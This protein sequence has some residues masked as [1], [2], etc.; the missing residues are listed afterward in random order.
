[1]CIGFGCVSFLPDG[2]VHVNEEIVKRYSEKDEKN[3]KIRE[4]LYKEK[5]NENLPNIDQTDLDKLKKL[6]ISMWPF[7]I[8]FFRMNDNVERTVRAKFEQHREGLD[9]G[10]LFKTDYE[11]LIKAGQITQNLKKDFVGGGELNLMAPGYPRYSKGELYV[12]D[13][14]FGIDFAKNPAK[15]INKLYVGYWQDQRPMQLPLPI[16]GGGG[17]SGSPLIVFWEKGVKVIGVHSSGNHN[18]D[19]STF[20][21]IQSDFSKEFVEAIL[22]SNDDDISVIQQAVIKHN[23]DK[24]FSGGDLVLNW[25]IVVYGHGD[26]DWQKNQFDGKYGKYKEK[27]K[28]LGKDEGWASSANLANFGDNMEDSYDG[29]N[30][31]YV[32]NRYIPGFEKVVFTDLVLMISVIICLCASVCALIVGFIVAIVGYAS[33]NKHH[34]VKNQDNLR[35]LDENEEE[36]HLV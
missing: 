18:Y 29:D 30:N 6:R 27:P 36:Q 28:K 9:V 32:Q 25:E 15:C 20:T 21:I 16:R 22:H 23:D 31:Y 35:E 33:F 14:E 26:Q 19:T 5:N 10:F 7:D 3:E 4:Y 34:K 17:L 12:R 8:A 13:F 24:T 2:W 11:S 1:M